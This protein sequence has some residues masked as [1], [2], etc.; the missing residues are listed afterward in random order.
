MFTIVINVFTT[1]N[2]SFLYILMTLQINS[3]CN[4]KR[5]EQQI[6]TI[7]KLTIINKNI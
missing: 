4:L 5:W 2:L 6:L 3:I 1:K 7:R